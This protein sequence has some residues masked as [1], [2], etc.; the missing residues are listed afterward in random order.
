[1]HGDG[2]TIYCARPVGRDNCPSD[3]RRTDMP[4]LHN[5]LPAFLGS[6]TGRAGIYWKD[7]SEGQAHDQS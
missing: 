1:M 6:V 4:K 2:M 3:Q 7:S 5:C